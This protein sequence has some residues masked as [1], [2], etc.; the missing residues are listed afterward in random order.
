MPL[1]LSEDYYVNVPLEATYMRAWDELPEPWREIVE[2]HS[3][4]SQK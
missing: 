1:F 2:G 3:P 4:Q